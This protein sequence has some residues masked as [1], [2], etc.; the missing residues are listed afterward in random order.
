MS[1]STCTNVLC[2]ILTVRLIA[3]ARLILNTKEIALKAA[4][5]DAAVK[6]KFFWGFESE[7]QTNPLLLHLQSCG[8]TLMPLRGCAMD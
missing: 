1:L 6:S 8:A 4:R 5:R 2:V 7:L 3:F